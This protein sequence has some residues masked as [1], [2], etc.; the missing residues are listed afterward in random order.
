MFSFK[1][2]KDYADL[3]LELSDQTD[4]RVE[5]LKSFNHHFDITALAVDSV[6]GLFAV[7]T[8]RGN[9]YIY[10]SPGVECRLSITDPPGTKV[11]LLQ[12]A[13]SASKL[14]CVDDHD[15]LHIWDLAAAGKPKL[16]KIVNFPRPVNCITVSPSHT[17][18]FV[19]LS[20]GEIKTYDLLCLRTSSYGVQNLWAAHEDR[21]MASG[22]PLPSLPG[23]SIIIDV[24]VHP[25][26]LNLVFVAHAGGVILYDLKE[27]RS[28]RTFELVNTPG[29]PGGG[30]YH[31]PDIMTHRRP[32]VSALAVHPS[33]HLL[34]AGHSDGSLAFWALDDEDRPLLV[35]T[36]DSADDEDVNMVDAVRLEAAR[37]NPHLA[38]MPAREP[39]FKLAWS[40][41]PNTS[42][43]RGGV[44][45]LTVLGGL[46]HGVATGVTAL[47]LP[48]LAPPAPPQ[49]SPRTSS[50]AIAQSFIHPQTR[51]AMREC[52]LPRDVYTYPTLGVP[53]DFLLVPHSNPHFAGAYDPQAILLLSESGMD[54]FG[55][56]RSLEAFEFPPP[57]FGEFLKHSTSEHSVQAVDIESEDPHAALGQELAETL[58]SLS[59]ARDPRLLG[60]PFTLS[61]VLGSTLVRVAKDAYQI[62]AS[63]EGR[64]SGHT[65]LRMEGGMAWAEDAGGEMKMMRYQPHRLLITYHPDYRVCFQDFSPQLLVGQ[66]PGTPL[67]HPFPLL[68]PALTIELTPLLIDPL[69]G[70]VQ[71]SNSTSATSRIRGDQPEPEEDPTIAFVRFAPESHEC[72]VVLS[73]GAVV[74]FKL[75][76]GDDAGYIPDAKDLFDEELI[77]LQHVRVRSGLRFRPFIGIK[78]RMG[79]VSACAISNIGFLAVAYTS[80]VLL[81]LD[82]RGPK[83]ILR[84]VHSDKSVL[85]RH[86]ERDPFALLT[87]TVCSTS[88]DPAPRIR[89]IA[90]VASGATTLYTIARSEDGA[91]NAVASTHTVE[92]AQRPVPGGSAVLDAKTGARIHASRDG[93]AAALRI[94]QHDVAEGET[95]EGHKRTVWVSAGAKGARCIANLTGERIAKTDWSSK[96]GAVLQTKVIEKNGSS[97]LV[98]FTDHQEALVYSLPFLELL[99]TLQLPPSFAPPFT[100]DDSGDAVSHALHPSGLARSTHLYTLFG[101]RRTSAYATPVIDLMHGRGTVPPHPQ[102]VSLIPTSVISSWLGYLA[103]QG[104]M[105]GEQIDALLAGPDRPVPPPVAIQRPHRPP[106][107]ERANMSESP[108]GANAT[109]APMSSGVGDMYNRLGDAL[110]ERGQMLGD[111]QESFDSLEQGSKRMLSQAK[112][113]AAQQSAKRWFNF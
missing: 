52:L 1:N 92:A 53:Q 13:I 6:S 70:L 103:G 87:W 29:A 30:G 15:R 56:T 64:G 67:Q 85:H 24:V 19:A 4:W 98:A 89:L 37:A 88:T 68:L 109:A 73:N 44:T 42:D 16:Q 60:L 11:R 83:I 43:P 3:S 93:L 107:T 20:T 23:S 51:S 112:T 41:F 25:R 113:L 77:H 110:A 79:Q 108:S 22:S 66:G 38:R 31:A 48:A 75:G 63:D 82:L 65:M 47:L 104:A 2:D 40:G 86:G 96:A 72:V 28:S 39:V 69:L 76:A 81:I 80:G 35:R 97:V 26:A 34:C 50:Q 36:L 33:G 27:Q 8:A 54:M 55:E 5:T 57:S 111:L 74:L 101:T 18:A 102:P 100:P 49:A 14:L 94:A 21:M 105:T 58:Q 84:R 45:V 106:P 71:S 90:T 95:A 91:W 78:P 17:H 46:L 61:G 10:G 59:L 12:F 32:S 99:Q 62:L 9:I 7:G